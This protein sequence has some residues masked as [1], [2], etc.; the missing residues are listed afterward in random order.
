MITYGL[1]NLQQC[2]E[3]DHRF[4]THFGDSRDYYGPLSVV[5]WMKIKKEREANNWTVKSYLEACAKRGI[6]TQGDYEEFR[7]KLVGIQ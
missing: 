2:T 5:N 3:S 1:D 7:Q 4:C 6:G